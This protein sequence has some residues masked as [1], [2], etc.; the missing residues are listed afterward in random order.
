M[1]PS[2]EVVLC[3]GP[4]IA[5]GSRTLQS[6]SPESAGLFIGSPGTYNSGTHDLSLGDPD[7]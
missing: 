5:E 1:T 6:R 3:Q 2:Q 7:V 4:I